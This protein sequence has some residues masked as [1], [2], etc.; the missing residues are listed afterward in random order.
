MLKELDFNKKIEKNRYKEEKKI[1]QIKMGDLQRA[2]RKKNIPVI[3][4]VEGFGTSGKGGLINEMMQS[5]DPR[6]ARVI[7]TETPTE[8]E[9]RFPFLYPF[10]ADSPAK[11]EIAIFDRGWYRRVWLERF[12]KQ[13]SQKEVEDYC[14]KINIFERQLKD[15]GTV[16]IKL[17]LGITQKEQKK[18]L[19][20]LL[21]SEDTSW[22]V[23]KDDLKR[24]EKYT[25]YFDMA[26]EMLE[27]TN[28][29]SAYWNVIE[30]MDKNYAVIKMMSIITKEMDLALTASEFTKN[31]VL[32][33]TQDNLS[34]NL[35]DDVVLDGKSLEEEIYKKK[36]KHLQKKINLY[37][38]ILYKRKIPMIVAFE[39]WDAAGKGGAIKRFTEAMDP[40]GYV[41][42]S[43][44]APNDFEK[45]HH[46]LWRFWIK[47]QKA[48]HITIFDRTWYGRV[49]VERIEHFCEQDDWKRAYQ[50][51]NEFEK[52]LTDYGAIV[53]KFWIHIDKEE[54][55]LRFE[56]RMANPEKQWKITDEDWRNR[57]K[58]DQYKIAV[59]EMI[60]K[61][62]TKNAPWTIVEG[63]NKNY[64]RIKVLETI[65]EAIER[66]LEEHEL[67]K[68][69][70]EDYT[71]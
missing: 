70:G 26:E 8:E 43:I 15:S 24:N 38:N 30:A 42:N 71:K 68:R 20:K 37:Q 18:R 57:E 28:T 11:G 41:V 29:N 16:I 3:I 12:N 21:S 39:G 51:I 69:D 35:L 49:L 34:S 46:Y 17:F 58:W 48:G 9:L 10:W 32:S 31:T 13:Y 44:S 62:S 63:N 54:Q 27:K 2:C 23:S 5:F 56:A 14:R 50:E 53:L 59:N 47:L 52:M 45:A 1:L 61:T 22:R 55:K 64:A 19:E 25:Q 36:L 65:V 60:R 66:R 33:E 40:R 6:G 7:T 67:S 4:L